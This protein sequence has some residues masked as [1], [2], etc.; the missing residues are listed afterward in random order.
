MFALIYSSQFT[1]YPVDTCQ[2]IEEAERVCKERFNM[3]NPKFGQTDEG[4]FYTLGYGDEGV[5]VLSL[6]EIEGTA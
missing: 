5:I 1:Q 2:T 6:Q 4:I 3:R